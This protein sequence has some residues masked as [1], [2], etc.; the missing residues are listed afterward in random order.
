MHYILRIV[1]RMEVQMTQKSEIYSETQLASIF[2]SAAAPRNGW[3]ETDGGR[4]AAG[5]KGK[6]GDCAVRAVAVA[7]GLDYKAAYNEL[8]AENAKITGV[9]SCRNG[10]WK[11]ALEA[12]LARYGWEW[13]SA[14]KFEGRHARA[15]DFTTAAGYSDFIIARMGRHFVAVLDGAVHDSWNSSHRAVYGYWCKA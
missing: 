6:T 10:I 3:V 1:K 5:Y 2:A 11:S 8:A 12:V 13:R 7:L 15:A 4:A 9:K 14:P